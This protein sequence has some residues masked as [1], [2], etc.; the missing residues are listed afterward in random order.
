MQNPRYATAYL[1]HPQ[2]ESHMNNKW[3]HQFVLITQE[4]E[5]EVHERD[6]EFFALKR[7]WFI[8]RL[9]WKAELLIYHSI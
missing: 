5:E 1:S 7:F 6:F 2:A 8:Y 9:C 4:E 3:I